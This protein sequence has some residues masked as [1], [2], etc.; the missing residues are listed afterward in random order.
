[1]AIGGFMAYLAEVGAE[2]DESQ[3]TKT[4]WALSHYAAKLQPAAPQP[5][6]PQPAPAAR[7]SQAPAAQA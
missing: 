1:V 7:K 6:A 3:Q 2:R 5:A 4:R